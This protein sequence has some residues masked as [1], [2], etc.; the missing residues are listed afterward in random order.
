MFKIHSAFQ[1]CSKK[2]DKKDFVY[3]INASELAA[4]ISSY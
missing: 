4:L 1:K 2:I 3:E